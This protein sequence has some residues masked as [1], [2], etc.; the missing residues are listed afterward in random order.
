MLP[1]HITQAYDDTVPMSSVPKFFEGVDI[2]Y[3]EN[4]LRHGVEGGQDAERVALVDVREGQE[5]GLTSSGKLGDE[6]RLQGFHTLTWRQLREQVRVVSNALRA[7]GVAK[8]DVVAALVGNSI[9]AVVMFLSTAT[10]GGVFTSISPDLGIEGCVARLQQV[11]PKILFA[12]ASTTYKGRH[13]SVVE[14]VGTVY[15]RLKR[16]PRVFV[17]PVSAEDVRQDGWFET[18]EDFVGLSTGEEIRFERVPFSYPLVI[19][20]TSGTT[21]EYI[22][23][24]SCL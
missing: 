8:G 20:Y 17:Y 7:A 14:K 9:R 2:N 23:T 1:S 11:T 21:G 5:L 19:C 10:V 18:W 16:K 3:A 12:D 15:G 24:I 4:V 22:S 13:A 6:D